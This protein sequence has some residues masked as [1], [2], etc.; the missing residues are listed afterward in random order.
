M[1]NA[2]FATILGL[3]LAACGAGI[4]IPGG[5][6]AT[7]VAPASSQWIPAAGQSIQ[8]QYDGKIDLG[9]KADIYDLDAFDTHASLVSRLHGMQRKALCSVDVGTW[10]KWRPDAKDF[11]QSVL[12]HKDGHW[13]GERWLDIR[14]TQILEPIM[15][16]RLQ[17]CKKKGFDGIDPDNIDGYQN[18][19]GFPLTAAEQLTYDEWVATQAH[20]IGLAVD[21]K[22]DPGQLKELDQY[23]DFA[24]DEQCFEQH[25]CDKLTPYANAGHLVVDIEYTN[26]M[27]QQRFL[28]K[29]CP[30][31]ASY[32][33]TGILKK[34]QLTSWIVTCSSSD[35]LH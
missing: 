30:S 8:I 13:A 3:A 16:A 15:S 20:L 6:N 5:S 17:L 10:E 7:S 4:S 11:P 18:K 32:S 35:F 29:A 12:G 23:F 27:N 24:V 34:L 19:T 14:Q 9:V 26:Q 2:I 28:S 25:W 33:I 1:R 31:D 22:N 21:Q